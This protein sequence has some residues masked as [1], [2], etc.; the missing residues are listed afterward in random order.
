MRKMEQDRELASQTETADLPE[1]R[2]GG[3]LDQ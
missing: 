3:E 2:A 1:Y